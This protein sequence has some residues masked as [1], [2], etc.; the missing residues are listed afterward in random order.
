M[1]AVDSKVIES[2]AMGKPLD[3]MVEFAPIQAHLD[4]KAT[5]QSTAA[6][7][8]AGASKKTDQEEIKLVRKLDL[9]ILPIMWAMYYLNW[10]DR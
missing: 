6:V 3:E 5:S 2:K 7:D 9:Y 4:E 8:Y 10:I 1:A